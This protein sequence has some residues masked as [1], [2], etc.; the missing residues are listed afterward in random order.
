MCTFLLAFYINHCAKSSKFLWFKSNWNKELHLFGVR[1]HVKAIFKCMNI[2][3]ITERKEEN[4]FGDQVSEMLLK[5][6][7]GW[8]GVW[9]TAE[10]KGGRRHSVNK[11]VLVTVAHKP[12]TESSLC[13]CMWWWRICSKVYFPKDL[14]ILFQIFAW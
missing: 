2:V 4:V 9:L 11:L 13:Y 1:N 6:L 3:F 7:S 10:P 5:P 12:R 8:V 14:W